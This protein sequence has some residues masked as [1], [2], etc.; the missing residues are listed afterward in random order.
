M[1]D[2]N[3]SGVIV[4]KYQLSFCPLSQA[5]DTGPSASFIHKFSEI[6]SLADPYPKK[7]ILT[8]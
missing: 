7:K 6:P 4:A 1:S 5:T 3:R 2:V 8:E